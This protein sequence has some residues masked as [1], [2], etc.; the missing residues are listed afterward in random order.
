MIEKYMLESASGIAGS[1]V[2]NCV[3]G[4][5]KLEW[6]AG[7]ALMSI[8]NCSDNCFS[9]TDIKNLTMSRAITILKACHDISIA[10]RSA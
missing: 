3:P 5:T 8:S 2:N 9:E 1:N 6:M 7:M 4:L 10:G